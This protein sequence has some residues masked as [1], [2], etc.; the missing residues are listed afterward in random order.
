MSGLKE[1]VA[2]IEQWAED[3]NIING[4]Q[5]IDQ[6]MKLFEEFGELAKNVAKDRDIKDDVGDV[7]VVLTNLCKQCNRSISDYLDREKFVASGIKV[8]VA[9]LGSELGAIATELYNNRGEGYF[10]EYAV[11]FA[12]TRLKNIAIQCNTTLEEC[13]ETAYNDIKD[14]K[15]LMYNGVFIKES[16][17]SYKEASEK[18]GECS[19]AQA[20][21][22]A[23]K[24]SELVEKVILSATEKFVSE[25]GSMRDVLKGD[26]KA[27]LGE[28]K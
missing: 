24:A 26:I 17:P 16:D 27:K 15:G 28:L 14:R 23:D 13:V 8:D 12:V 1:L 18:L 5:P 3:R 20:Q 7:F 11:S 22:Q 19:N 25:G 10:P 6:A 4:T 9:F 2:L 21:E